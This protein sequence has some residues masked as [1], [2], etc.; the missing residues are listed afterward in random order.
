MPAL[1]DKH[2]QRISEYLKTLGWTDSD[3]LRFIEY[4]TQ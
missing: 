1:N 2:I 3:I 4:I